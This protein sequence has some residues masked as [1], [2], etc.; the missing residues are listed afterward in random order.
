VKISSSKEVQITA[1]Y[2]HK[3]NKKFNGLVTYAVLSSDGTTLYCTTLVNGKAS[4]C[5]CPSHKPCYHMKGL[6]AK[7]AARP[8]AAKRLPV[9][10]TELVKSGKLAVPGKKAAPV[11]PKVPVATLIE[12]AVTAKVP[13]TDLSKK[14]NLNTGQEFR[15]MR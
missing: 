5:S 11:A 10:T 13:T 9:W 6:E 2:A 15:M 14:G 4:G 8:F 3:T 7:E 12:Q 1:R